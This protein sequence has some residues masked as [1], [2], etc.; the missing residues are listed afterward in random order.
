MKAFLASLAALALAALS[1]LAAEAGRPL[2]ALN[3]LELPRVGDFGLRVL[4]PDVLELALVTTKK[5]DAPPERWNFIGENFKPGL[6]APA[7]FAVKADGKPVAVAEVGFKRRPIYAPLKQR[8][9]RIGNWLYLKLAAPVADGAAVS[10]ANP[11]GSLWKEEKFEAKALPGR[12]SPAIHVN[13]VGYLPNAPKKALVGFYLGSLGELPV[14]EGTPFEVQDA[15][16]GTAAFS[17]KLKPRPDQGWAYKVT[18]Y[19]RVM[20]A[21]FTALAKPGEYRLA[22]PGLGASFP[23]TVGE[24][25]AACLARTWALGLYH[26]ACGMANAMP[27]TRFTH[28]P[29]HTAPALIPDAD[30]AFVNKAIG[31]T[32]GEGRPNPRHTAP[33]M[34]DLAAALYPFVKKGTVDVSG[35]HHDAGDYSKYT[36]NVAH[37]IHSLVLAVDVFPGAA[38]L[39]NLGLPESGDGKGDLLQAAKWEADFLAK[40][41]DDDGGFFFLVYPRTRKY[42]GDVLPDAGDLQLVYPKNTAATAAAVGALAQA[43]SSPRFREAFPEDAKR[44][45]AAARRGWDFLEKAFAKHGEDGAYQKITHYGDVTMHDDELAW[46]ASELYVATG[47]ERFQ[48]FVLKH[49]DPTDPKTRKWG[50]VRLD[51]EYAAAA[52]AF[53]FAELTGRLPAAKLNKEH[54]EKCRTELLAVAQDALGWARQSAYGTSFPEPSKRH[55]VAGWYFPADSAFHAA[56]ADRIS[57]SPDWAELALGNLNFE[58]GANPN[59]LVFLTGLGWRRQ[60]EIVHQYAQNDRRVLPPSG[61]P[62]GSVQGGFFYMDHYKKDLGALTFPFDG[63]ADSPFPFYDRWGDSFNTTT[64]FT[65]NVCGRGLA[66][67]AWLMGKTRLAAQPWKSAAARIEGAPARPVAGQPFEVSL[68]VE[69]LDPAAALVVWEGR[70]HEPFLGAKRTFT[71]A[72]AGPFWIEAEA[73]WPDGRRAF[74]V[75]E[76]SASPRDGARPAAAAPGTL[77]LENFDGRGG[78]PW[79]PPSGA[80]LKGEPR[81]APDNV[82]WMAEPAGAA[83]GLASFDDEVRLPIPD[84]ARL[85]GRWTLSAWVYVEKWGWGRVTDTLL[86]VSSE[87]GKFVTGLR[88]DK[89][90]KPPAPQLVAA[91]EQLARPPDLAPAFRLGEWQRVEIESGDAVVLRVDGKEVARATPK[92]PRKLIP[93]ANSALCVVAGHWLGCVDDL[94]LRADPR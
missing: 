48:E 60:R 55:R 80:K 6:P 82:A 10:V 79:A 61:I 72:K 83:L 11:D 49:F 94:H 45:L 57:P 29:C 1:G 73:Q 66:A 40:M 93:P 27:F 51:E 13:Q 34:K 33:R 4:A 78:A 14:P 23:F 63:D 67:T 30:H 47:E 25:A 76:F 91:E 15:A 26:Q 41:Q 35:G 5:A 24:E 36:V 81:A 8:D 69:G 87:D 58:L 90:A 17:G 86:A 37:L 89:W 77:L 59:N 62:L 44:W 46:A 42:E 54:V 56:V 21:D 19:Q 75:K 92:E 32:S 2:D 88:F 53:A 38:S 68:A 31:G 85:S 50:W 22:V 65:V 64:E 52:H 3:P 20:E 70:D 74:A 71:P 18:P 12:L 28:A 39:D 84:A 43:G 7:A 9:L 16:R